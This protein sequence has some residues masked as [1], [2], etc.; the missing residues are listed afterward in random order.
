MLSPS[1]SDCED[2]H[3]HRSVSRALNES[4]FQ[5]IV[6]ERD[7]VV[8][9]S[10]AEIGINIQQEWNLRG[11]A[12][13][14][15]DG[16]RDSPQIGPLIIIDSECSSSATT[17]IALCYSTPCPFIPCIDVVLSIIS[18]IELFSTIMS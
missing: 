9:A 15:R 18:N 3:E 14:P 5:V 4:R 12:L 16:P 11:M 10:Q 2:S 1:L 17:T 7:M 8:V 13:L 6:N